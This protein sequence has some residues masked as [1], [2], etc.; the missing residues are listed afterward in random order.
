MRIVLVPA[1]PGL[2][3]CRG[4]IDP[5]EEARAA[6]LDALSVALASS[7]T[8]AVLGSEEIAESLLRQAGF[9]GSLVDG[10]AD[11]V[12]VSA[13]GSATRTEKAPGFFDERAADFD[14]SIEAALAHGDAGALAA[15]DDEL[16]RELWCRGVPA[17]RAMAALMPSPITTTVTYADAPYGVAYWVA[18][19]TS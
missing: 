17:F 16:A 11:L 19:W 15:L 7:E 3:P 14:K 2:L 4:L 1:A 5:F 9:G 18:T 8:V 12:V 6:A 10:L 13:D